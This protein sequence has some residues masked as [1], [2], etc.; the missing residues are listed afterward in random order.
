MFE[1]LLEAASPSRS[2]CSAQSANI[3]ILYRSE[4]PRECVAD[5]DAARCGCIDV[6]V[7]LS[8]CFGQSS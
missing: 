3:K 4:G 7:Q 6:G 8:V 5:G 2:H 1:M